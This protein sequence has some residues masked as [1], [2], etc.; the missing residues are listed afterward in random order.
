MN[1]FALLDLFQEEVDTHA[2]VLTS[3]LIALESAPCD[4]VAIEPLMRAAHSL[5]G[6]ARVI[7]LDTVVR[8][9]HAMEDGLVAAMEGKLELTPARIDVLLHAVDWITTLAAVSEADLPGWLVTQADAADEIEQR[10]TV[11]ATPPEDPAIKKQDTATP[12]PENTTEQIATVVAVA[13]IRKDTIAAP[14]MA[15]ALGNAEPKLTNAVKINADVL[16]R[17]I[18]LAS[19]SLVEAHRIDKLLLAFQRIRQRLT[20]QNASLR[21]NSIQIGK[22]SN[23]DEDEDALAKE[24]E[25]FD[26]IQLALIEGLD[27]LDAHARR[28]SLIAESQFRE[29]IASRMQPFEEGARSFP[30]QVRDLARDLGKQVNFEIKGLETS[31]DRDILAKLEAPLGHLL[32]NA[33]DHGLES[34][35]ER[36]MAGKPETASISLE[37]R[38]HAGSLLITVSDDGRG[39]DRERLRKKIVERNLTTTELAAGMNDGELFDFLFLPGLS[40]R[41]KLSQVSGRGVGLDVVQSMVQSAG[42]QVSVKSELGRGTVFQLQLPITRSVVRALMVEIG[43]ERYALPLARIIRLVELRREKL[44]LVEGRCY[45]VLDGVNIALIPSH[46]LLDLQRAPEEN[47]MIKAVMLLDRG[48]YYAIEVECFLGESELVVRPLDPRLGRIPHIASASIDESGVPLLVLDID[49]MLRSIASLLAGGHP[50]GRREQTGSSMRKNVRR[51]L[52]V[53]DSITVRELERRVFE[54]QGY[55][56]NV[57]VDGVD[58]WN[59]LNLGN[60]D[61]V[62]TD[63]DMPRMTGIELVKLIRAD[64]IL[65]RLPV[66]MVS[67][68]DRPED[69]KAG[70]EA[71][72]SQYL[73]KSEFQDD[74]LIKAV[75]NL[76]GTANI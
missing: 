67:Y 34:R 31:I 26:Q 18:N 73:A 16:N 44:N 48:E 50:V 76:I 14:A 60:F 42:G 2:N 19:E 10:L 43:A 65:K 39:V 36:L 59:A 46:E 38:H 70:L 37:A 40:T 30:R 63:V 29:V 15:S 41:E 57:A 13:T 5:K 27:D 62:V 32:R 47:D 69:K 28:M 49:D 6:A 74:T 3:G 61:L 21:R 66:L 20:Q 23:Y 52:I 24:C 11:L 53:D 1:D 45:F 75:Q 71:G 9:A 33:L 56:V 35:E 17:F 12:S 51:I 4:A 68:K 25:A 58:G 64:A 55:E 72:A 22:N 7:G 8:I 54:R